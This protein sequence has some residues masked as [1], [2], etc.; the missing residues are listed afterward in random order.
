MIALRNR[1]TFKMSP[2][3]NF[4]RGILHGF[5]GAGLFRRLTYP[6]APEDIVDTRSVDE[7]VE[8]GV[9]MDWLCAANPVLAARYAQDLD[10]RR[11]DL[12]M[13]VHHPAV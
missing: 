1:R 2:K 7:L 3:V 5:T 9:F 6:G 11:A 12:E 8:S 10:H 13:R 4:A